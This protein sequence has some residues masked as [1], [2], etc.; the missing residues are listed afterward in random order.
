MT[1]RPAH[2]G[3][4]RARGSRAG[5]TALEL[6]MA[7][8]V[9]AV[10]LLAALGVFGMM[11]RM[12]RFH[13]ARFQESADTVF[14]HTVVRR[15]MQTLVA[16]APIDGGAELE[17]ATGFGRENLRPREERQDDGNDELRREM[18]RRGN[19]P[20]LH[21]LRG[22][23]RDDRE[24]EGQTLDNLGRVIFP[25]SMLVLEPSGV[26]TTSSAHAPSRLEVTMLAAGAAPPS[27]LFVRGA[28]EVEPRGRGWALLYRP[29]APE[30]DPIELLD[31]VLALEWQVVERGVE[32]GKSMFTRTDL[33][34]TAQ[35]PAPEDDTGGVWRSE[36]SAE[37][38]A[39]FP[40]AVR[41]R[42]LLSTGRSIDW[43]FEPSITTGGQQ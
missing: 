28:F 32:A 7:T 43:L 33:R 12:D 26:L 31:G 8:A 18:A 3:V 35:T 37:T 36:L 17:R 38:P 34:R 5:F 39:D 24:E 42:A 19:I 41:L 25:K 2:P 21:G 10:V 14:A 11:E 22:E 20:M 40:K 29:I 27:A 9:G 30:G 15:A 13:S 4:S 1:R 6:M 23:Y 16:K